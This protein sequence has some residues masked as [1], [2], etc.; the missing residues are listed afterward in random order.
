MEGEN[1]QSSSEGS[2]SSKVW[3][4]KFVILAAGAFMNIVLGLIISVIFTAVSTYQTGIPTT[5]VDHVMETSPLYGFLQK[6]D[7]VV[8]ING[9]QANIKRDIDF[10]M[11]ETGGNTCEIVILRNGEK[12]SKTFKNRATKRKPLDFSYKIKVYL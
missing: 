9:S 4:K 12:I 10:A 1:E 11:Q 6:G 7:K 8:S 3:Y 2:F 5:T